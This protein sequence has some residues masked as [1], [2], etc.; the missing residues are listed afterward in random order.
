MKMHHL[1]WENAGPPHSGF[2]QT[3][4][5]GCQHRV[6][7]LQ[8][9]PSPPSHPAARVDGQGEIH[10]TFPEGR[11][12]KQAGKKRQQQQRNSISLPNEGSPWQKAHFQKRTQWSAG[13][14]GGNDVPAHLA[15]KRALWKKEERPKSGH[16]RREWAKEG[17]GLYEK[18]HRFFGGTQGLESSSRSCFLTGFNRASLQ[19]PNARWPFLHFLF[20]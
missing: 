10:P 14:E 15:E 17:R 19:Q 18:N 12:V 6:A 5:G 1:A 11:L 13:K 4:R 3:I 9:R 20:C 16:H 8:G 7:F 2:E